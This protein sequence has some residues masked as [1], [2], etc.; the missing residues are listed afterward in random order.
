MASKANLVF[1]LVLSIYATNHGDCAHH[2]AAVPSPAA[3][4]DC[5]TLVLNMA[6]CLSF[7]QAGSTVTKPQGS[8]CSG[9]KT[10]LKADAECLCEAFRSSASLGVTL[11]VTKAQ[12]LPSLCKVSAPSAT[13]CAL[14]LSPAGA[15]TIGSG[16]SPTAAAAPTDSV[17]ANEQAPAPAPGISVLQAKSAI[18]LREKAAAASRLRVLLQLRLCSVAAVIENRRLLL[19]PLRLCS[20]SASGGVASM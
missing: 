16:L 18:A 8:C 2:H 15:P 12:T 10:V 14:S 20:D 4:V 11:N 9:L 5:S 19:L 3:S 7:V 13:N 1:L 6:D 17:A